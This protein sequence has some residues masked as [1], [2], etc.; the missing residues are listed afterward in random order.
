MSSNKLTIVEFDESISSP[1]HRSIKKNISVLAVVAVVITTAGILSGYI[2]FNNN[3]NEL[4][5][6]ELP[7]EE[8]PTEELPTEEPP[9]ET[10]GSYTIA[11]H[12]W[13]GYT[14]SAQV[15]VEV[16]KQKLGC[17]I[18]Q[19][20]IAEAGKSYDAMEAGKI[21]V[22]IEDWGSGRW[23]EWTKRGAVIKAGLNGNFGLIGMYVVPWMVKKYPDITNSKNLNKYAYLFKT[24]KSGGKGVWFDGPPGYTTISQKMIA[25]N[26]LNF[27]VISSSSEEELFAG[28]K[29]AEANKTPFL[30]YFYQPQANFIQIPNLESGRIIFP[31]NDWNDPALASGLTDYPSL[32]LVK[33]ISKKLN[34][35]NDS[36]TSLVKKF[37]WTNNDQNSV[38]ADI[39]KGMT[40]SAAAKKW[41]AANPKTVALWLG[42]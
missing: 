32:P 8:L 20:T 17:K 9:V 16:A 42:K 40:P 10:C 25:A 41:I 11:M 5:T 1:P 34:N 7:T 14:A 4:P 28:F 30:G 39:G 29:K 22:I 37:K 27:K 19:K 18:A 23:Q 33:L 3:S 35:A 12:A 6:E 2:K 26:K 31:A 38:S 13:N 21:D 15:V 36:F 24:A